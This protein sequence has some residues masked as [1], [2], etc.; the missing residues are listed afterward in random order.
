MVTIRKNFRFNDWYDARLFHS[1]TN[2]TSYVIFITNFYSQ[3]INFQSV[4]V[5][6][7]SI[8]TLHLTHSSM[9]NSFFYIIL[10]SSFSTTV[11]TTASFRISWSA[12]FQLG[13]CNRS[14]LLKMEKLYSNR[15]STDFLDFD[16]AREAIRP[17]LN[18]R[19]H[20]EGK[21]RHHRWTVIS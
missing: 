15:Q 5:C 21:Q 2:N 6:K 9:W 19:L 16:G 7:P 20:S 12:G 13:F 3:L 4:H 11:L 18:L 10:D 14:R 8:N 1:N 17:T